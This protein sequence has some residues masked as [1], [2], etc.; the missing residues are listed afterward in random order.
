M[1]LKVTIWNE[2]IHEQKHEEVR[3]VYPKGIHGAIADGIRLH[4][5][6][7]EIRC[8]TQDMPEH[9]LTEQLLAQTDVLLWWGHMGHSQVQDAIVER[10]QARVLT[11][12]GAI[13]L[14]SAHYSKPFM[15]LMGTGCGLKWRDSG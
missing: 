13:F 14:H 2:Y 4:L 15:R 8:V 9:G 12:M 7:A 3:R 6:Q 10:V 5:P 1:P 11:G